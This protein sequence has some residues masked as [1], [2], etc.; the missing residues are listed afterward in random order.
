MAAR[1]DQSYDPT[2]PYR[3]V[4]RDLIAARWGAVWR[5][6]PVAIEGT[7]PEGVHDVRVASRR[8]RAAMDVSRAFPPHGTARST[9]LR[10]K[11]PASL[12][13]CATGM[14]SS[15]TSTE[16][17]TPRRLAIIPASTASSSG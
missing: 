3:G 7:D 9:S 16:H 12:A 15:N 5:A 1:S 17:E 2:L 4:M 8:L 6:V 14:C 11:S 13:P 10:S